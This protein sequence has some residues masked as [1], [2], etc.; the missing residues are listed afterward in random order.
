M[1][2]KCD[3]PLPNIESAQYFCEQHQH[4][5]TTPREKV[6]TVL[7]LSKHPLGAYE[8]KERLSTS[9]HEV[10]PA[11]IYR[12][13]EFWEKHGFIHKVNSL[14]A[15]VACHHEHRH[16][17]ASYTLFICDSCDESFELDTQ[18]IVSTLKCELNRKNFS[19]ASSSTEIRGVCSSC[20]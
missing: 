17:P 4:R 14:N 7:M 8:I 5:F 20:H 19:L 13:I 3:S 15:Y 1:V 18:K 2:K 10:K 12:A 16:H 9:M 11:T 6:L